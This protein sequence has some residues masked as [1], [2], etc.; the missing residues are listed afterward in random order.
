MTKVLKIDGDLLAVFAQTLKLHAAGLHG[1]QRV[2]AAL[3][4]ID[5][6]MDMGAP[7]ANQN[8]SGQHK[9]T[10][11]PLHAQPLGLRVAAVAG[12]TNALFM[13]EKL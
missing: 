9:L 1:K 12:G 7:L 11:A 8:V 3:A 6:G 10:V 2:V 5:T 4:Y 13:G